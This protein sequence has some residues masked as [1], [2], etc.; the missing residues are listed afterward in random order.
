MLKKMINNIK[1]LLVPTEIPELLGSGKVVPL[2]GKIFLKPEGTNLWKKKIRAIVSS[3]KFPK[4]V[5]IPIYMIEGDVALGIIRIKP[6][7]EIDEKKFNKLKEFHGLSDEDRKR[8]WPYENI[9][10]YYRIELISKFNPP[11][12]IIKP[13]DSYSWLDEVV[14]KTLDIGNPKE[15]K[16]EDLIRGH[17]LIHGLWNRLEAASD[18]CIK[19]HIVFENELLKRKL[20]HEEIDSL[21]KRCK[22]IK[23]KLSKKGQG[24]IFDRESGSIKIE[25]LEKVYSPY[26]DEYTCRLNS[27]DKYTSFARKNCVVKSNG[28]CIDFIYGIKDGKSELQSMRYKKNIWSNSSAKNHCSEKNGSFEQS[29]NKL[30]EKDIRWNLNLSEAFDVCEVESKAANFEYELFTRFLGCS[31]KNIYQNSYSIPSPLLGT[32]LSG[33]KKVLSEFKLQDS[34]N[35]S[36]N[37]G[38]VPLVYETIELNSNISDDFLIEGISFYEVNDENKLVMK[39]NPTMF[40]L[41]VHLFSSNDNRK[42]NK[43]LLGEVHKWVK[44]NNFLK[45]E[46]FGLSGEFLNKTKD[47]Y[48]DLFLEKDVLNSIIKS[49]N[50]LNEKGKESPSRGLMFIGKPGTGKTKTGKILMNTLKNTTFIWVSSRDFDKVGSNTAIKIGFSLAR[51][52]AP[53]VLFMEDIDS[54]LRDYSIDLLKTEMDGMKENKGII[55]VLTSNTPEKFPDALLD[56]PGRFHDVLEFSLPDKEIRKIMIE[57]WVKEDIDNK[58]MN[59]ILDATEGCSGAHIKELVD[60]AKLIKNDDKINIGESLLKSLEKLKKQKNLIDRIKKDNK[61][62]DPDKQRVIE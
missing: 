43:E 24:V 22:E 37:G 53:T 26:K 38:E 3:E 40:G 1:N 61:T 29:V 36:Y 46:I 59:S 52:L 17:Q 35:F 5:D 20:K 49:V 34:R 25:K 47:T 41:E 12:K 10:Y 57:K 30:K 51:D 55:T 9:L 50:Q 14:F 18:D 23:E 27:P 13:V 6:A 56:R 33:F 15:F 62:L 4:Y 54:W 44:E 2:P 32:Y 42:W 28:K 16:N 48:D 60:F 31:V 11:K 39:I 58:L 45:G 19:Y 7:K 8:L 21:D